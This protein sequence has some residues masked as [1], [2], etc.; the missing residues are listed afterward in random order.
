MQMSAVGHVH[1][2]IYWLINLQTQEF[3][4]MLGFLTAKPILEKQQS[5]S[6][7]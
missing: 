1:S 6:A 5:W 2:L 7:K 3:T 4:F